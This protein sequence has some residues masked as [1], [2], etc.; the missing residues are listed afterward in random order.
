MIGLVMWFFIEGRLRKGKL[1]VLLLLFV[2]GGKEG[3]DGGVVIIKNKGIGVLNSELVK[4]KKM[5]DRKIREGKVV[6][7]K[8]DSKK[9]IR[10]WLGGV[11]GEEELIFLDGEG[12]FVYW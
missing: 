2:G 3:V 7:I 1:L 12:F 6:D 5:L 9:R 4:K 11:E 8:V 10:V